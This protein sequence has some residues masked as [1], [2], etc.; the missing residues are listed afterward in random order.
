MRRLGE[1]MRT[2]W[3]MM[4]GSVRALIQISFTSFRKLFSGRLHAL[5]KCSALPFT[6]RQSDALAGDHHPL[7]RA[8][9]GYTMR[10]HEQERPDDGE[11]L[12]FR[13]A[14]ERERRRQVDVA[15]ARICSEL[16]A[17]RGAEGC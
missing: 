12:Q 16:C 17:G 9:R 3:R 2:I 6:R 8:E 10:R 13:V 14:E 5:R 11:H 4:D 7:L 15:A 1:Y